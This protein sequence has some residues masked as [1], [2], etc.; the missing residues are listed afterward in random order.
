MLSW[1]ECISNPCLCLQ[2][3]NSSSDAILI[4]FSECPIKE[5]EPPTPP[6]LEFGHFFCS[7]F[8]WYVC[9]LYKGF[10]LTIQSHKSAQNCYWEFEHKEF[11]P[12][13]QNNSLRKLHWES[14]FQAKW[15]IKESPELRRWEDKKNTNAPACPQWRNANPTKQSRE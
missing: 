10:H 4:S 11:L 5:L 14:G 1:N 7:D 2:V 6:K 13:I 15:T 12:R 8:S 9:L 3:S